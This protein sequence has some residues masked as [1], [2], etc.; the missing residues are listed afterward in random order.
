LEIRLLIIGS[1][2][3]LAS[4]QRRIYVLSELP[5]QKHSWFDSKFRRLSCAEDDL[6]MEMPFHH[7]CKQ[8]APYLS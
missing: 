7:L 1:D 5:L 4:F 3:T 2:D 8:F 6:L